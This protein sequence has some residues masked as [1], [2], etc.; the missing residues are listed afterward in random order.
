MVHDVAAV[1]EVPPTAHRASRRGVIVAGCA[2]ATGLLSGRVGEAGAVLARSKAQDA[3]V[4]RLVLQLE[5]TQVAFYEQ[6]LARAG[7]KG[8]LRE[9]A[10]TA[11]GH[12]RE[13]LAAIR[14]A[15]GKT[16][17]AP[18]FEFGVRTANNGAFVATAIELEDIAVAAYN[19]Q[20]TNLTKPTLAAAA[21]IV[22]VEARHAA[23]VRAL[24]S[25]V[26]APHPVDKPMTA[27]DAANRLF[28]IGLRP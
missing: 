5:Q 21:A 20:A 15:L 4:L 6:A 9:F 11:L 7:L 24:E 19:G 28:A 14:K 26:A 25:K 27:Q 2:L 3:L 1:E 17:P 23:W 16:P 22:S 13:H 12:E 18:T 8:A 10:E